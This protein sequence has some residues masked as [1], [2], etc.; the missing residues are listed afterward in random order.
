MEEY[1]KLNCLFYVL[2]LFVAF[3]PL[4][5]LQIEE[6]D[7]LGVWARPIY[8]DPREWEYFYFSE[9]EGKTYCETGKYTTN[10]NLG[11]GANRKRDDDSFEC[12]IEPMNDPISGQTWYI[13]EIL[14]EASEGAAKSYPFMVFQKT[15]PE[16]QEGEG[17]DP[18]TYRI[19]RVA[20]LTVN[21]TTE[22]QFKGINFEALSSTQSG[23]IQ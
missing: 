1:M 21:Q 20:N 6:A 16:G 12:V 10:P 23:G 19:M 8:E 2:L 17:I 18:L 5:C 11:E 3:F 14:P 9:V 13:Q 7:M 15:L 4:G 22:Y